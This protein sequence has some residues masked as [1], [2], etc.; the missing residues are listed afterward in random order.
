MKCK[1]LYKL[2]EWFISGCMFSAVCFLNRTHYF[3]SKIKSS[4]KPTGKKKKTVK[5][6]G[7]NYKV[8]VIICETPWL[9]QWNL[10]ISSYIPFFFQKGHWFNDHTLL[11]NQDLIKH[12]QNMYKIWLK[13]EWVNIIRCANKKQD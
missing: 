3:N 10:K 7:T 11:R 13:P 5:R 6:S 9:L 1:Q 8:S 4:N 12:E 2:W